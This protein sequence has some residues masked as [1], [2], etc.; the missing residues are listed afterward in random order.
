MV[1]GKMR[2]SSLKTSATFVITWRSRPRRSLRKGCTRS[3]EY[4]SRHW[5]ELHDLGCKPYI[6]R[7]ILHYYLTNEKFRRS[8]RPLRGRRPRPSILTSPRTSSCTSDHPEH[9]VRLIKMVSCPYQGFIFS[10]QSA[11]APRVTPLPAR[12]LRCPVSTRE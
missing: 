9:E 2:R 5:T 8:E 6:I 11:D 1:A 10:I 4:L 12:R 7:I 3:V